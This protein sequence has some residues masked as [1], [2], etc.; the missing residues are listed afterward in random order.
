MAELLAPGR[1]AGL[2]GDHARPLHGGYGVLEIVSGIGI[3]ASDRPAVW[4]WSRV[5]GD[6][7]DLATLA[8]ACDN[9]GPEDREQ[10]VSSAAAVG[11]I[12]FT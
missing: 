8:A 9:A 11:S 10:I 4:L 2:T 3:R 5:L 1:M 6:A 12:A 7:L